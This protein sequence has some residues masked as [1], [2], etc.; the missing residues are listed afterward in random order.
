MSIK[1][2]FIE[3]LSTI[4]T[5]FFSLR[6]LLTLVNMSVRLLKMFMLFHL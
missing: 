6:A 5:F 2:I 1:I 4:P 3:K